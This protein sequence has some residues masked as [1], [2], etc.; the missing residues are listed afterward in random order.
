MC[1]AW[2]HD[3][4]C[5]CGFG[6]EN[7]SSA[8]GVDKTTVL[9]SYESY[10]NP[11]ARCPVCHAGVFFFQ[12]DNGGRVFFDE[13][14]PPW[15]KH[16]CTDRTL[17]YDTI[18]IAIDR[19]H[20]VP[21]ESGNTAWERE[22]WSPF[23]LLDASLPRGQ[24]QYRVYGRILKTSGPSHISIIMDG[25]LVARV[26]DWINRWDLTAPAFFRRAGGTCEL[27][28]VTLRGGQIKEHFLNGQGW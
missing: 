2:N 25:C 4:Y 28:S 27:S 15:P 20:P 10:V 26:S 8:A 17:D 6:G 7:Y 22:G 12:A 13:L 14:G 9:A 21:L 11:F 16:S 1:N 5:R 23:L 18:A 19:F 24:R 3:S